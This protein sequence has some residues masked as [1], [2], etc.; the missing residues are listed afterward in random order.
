MF[1]VHTWSDSLLNTFKVSVSAN[2]LKTCIRAVVFISH[3]PHFHCWLCMGWAWECM[4]Q[5]ILAL[6]ISSSISS[7]SKYLRFS[8]YQDSFTL[9]QSTITTLSPNVGLGYTSDVHFLLVFFHLFSASSSSSVVDVFPVVL[10]I[11]A[12]LAIPDVGVWWSSRIVF[13]C[14]VYFQLIKRNTFFCLRTCIRNE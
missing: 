7:S 4:S 13:V 9:L 1:F 14:L 6:S 3:S 11:P 8:S 5:C 12:V 2:E 10:V